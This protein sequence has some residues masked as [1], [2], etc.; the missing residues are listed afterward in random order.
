LRIYQ[1]LLSWPSPCSPWPKTCRSIGQICHLRWLR[2]L[3]N[4]SVARAA[5]KLSPA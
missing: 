1:G 2:M 3:S 5:T 4:F